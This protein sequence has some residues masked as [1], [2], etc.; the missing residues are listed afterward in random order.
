MP[1]SH[2]NP[3]KWLQL[4]VIKLFLIDKIYSL[5]IVFNPAIKDLSGKEVSVSPEVLKSFPFFY[6]VPV[7]FNF[8]TSFLFSNSLPFKI[9][10]QN[11]KFSTSSTSKG[12]QLFPTPSTIPPQTPTT[13]YNPGKD[14]VKKKPFWYKGVFQRHDFCDLRCHKEKI[15]YSL[16]RKNQLF[17]IAYLMVLALVFCHS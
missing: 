9:L 8:S 12:S 6:I 11:F 1:K 5:E 14:G 2:D 17:S 3:L 10:C 16:V 7:D 4:Q 15:L 13:I